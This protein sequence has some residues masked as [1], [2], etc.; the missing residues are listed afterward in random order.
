MTAPPY[1]AAPPRT[2]LW[3]IVMVLTCCFAIYVIVMPLLFRKTSGGWPLAVGA[4]AADVAAV[5][6]R[7]C[8][9]SASCCA[10]TSARTRRR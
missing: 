10:T 3:P 1:P 6:A 2:W 5:G 8:A 9:M 7:T 4:A